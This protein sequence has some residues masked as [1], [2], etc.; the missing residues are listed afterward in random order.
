MPSYLD[1]NCTS[2]SFKSDDILTRAGQPCDARLLPRPDQL[3][4]A[5]Q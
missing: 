2:P 5:G 4:D 1:K 3:A